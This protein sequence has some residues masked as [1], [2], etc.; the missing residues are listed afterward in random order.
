MVM[1][2]F[3]RSSWIGWEKRSLPRPGGGSKPGNVNRNVHEGMHMV[4]SSWNLSGWKKALTQSTLLLDGARV[5]TE[6]ESATVQCNHA[7]DGVI[8]LQPQSHSKNPND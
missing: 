2:V 5:V 1:E 7:L 4:M 8:V 3:P 6:G